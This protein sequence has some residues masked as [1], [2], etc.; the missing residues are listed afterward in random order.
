M[1]HFLT[2]LGVLFLLSCPLFAK[3]PSSSPYGTCA[4]LAGGEEHNQMPANLIKMREAGISWA[5]ADFSWWGIEHPQGTWHFEHLDRLMDLADL[6]GITILPILDYSTPW[7]SPSYKHPEEWLEYVRQVVTRYK[8][9]IRYW[10][11]WNEENIKSYWGDEAKAEDYA[12]FLKITYEEIKKI[13][14]ELVVVYGGLAGVPAEF[15]EESLKAGAGKYFDVINIHPYRA[16]MTSP[17]AVQRFLSDIQK[18]HD[19]T[20]RYTGADKPCWI[21]EMGWA[22]SPFLWSNSKA[23]FDGALKKCFP[24]G[25]N[26]PVSVLR[27]VNYPPSF[28]IDAVTWK[29]LLPTDAKLETISLSD[30]KTLNPQKR[31]VLI[32]PPGEDFPTALAN[33]LRAYVRDGGTLILTGGIPFYYNMLPTESGVWDRP[34]N[35]HAG[36]QLANSFRVHWIAW[37][38]EKGTPEKSALTYGPEATEVLAEYS[39]SKVQGSRF[40]TSEK[41][42]EGDSFEPLFIATGEKWTAGPKKD[43]AFDAPA[44]AIYRFRSDWK[45]MIAVNAVMGDSFNT[46]RCVPENQ[47]VFLSQAILLALANGVDRFFSYEFQAPERDEVDPESHFGIMRHDLTPKTG[48]IAYQNLTKARP[49]GSVNLPG[50]QFLDEKRLCVLSWKRPD[51]KIGYAVW[52]PAQSRG[53]NV[54]VVAGTVT[55]AFNYLGEPVKISTKMEFKP[56]ITY[57]IGEELKMNFGAL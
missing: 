39:L 18:F 26:G 15:F 52:T 46:N 4:H 36:I 43:E 30:C 54:K 50:E 14:P 29:S 25:V 35:L 53:Y 22:S 3:A 12:R 16:G 7:A 21:T 57:F 24:S 44:A 47:G 19:L 28:A 8:D 49:E 1:Y 11:V 31:P 32:L 48:Y 56:G 33:E 23:F 13:D 37:W 42:K 20:V 10:E 51:G 45:G 17:A 41:L 55:E 38:T 2:V 6:Y 5:R 9:R 40:F 27:D 34:A